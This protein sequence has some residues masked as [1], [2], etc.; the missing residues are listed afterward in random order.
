MVQRLLANLS[1]GGRINLGFGIVL[2]M[3]LV[4]AG[5]GILGANNARLLFRDFDATSD[6]T[7]A[8]LRAE[9]NIIDLSRHIL[10]Y[11]NQDSQPSLDAAR[12]L[13][14]TLPEVLAEAD[15]NADAD[16]QRMLGE[17]RNLVQDFGAAVEDVWRPRPATSPFSA[18]TWCRPAR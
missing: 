11:L 18:R 8:I 7:R 12:D 13:V 9:R 15:A 2:A 6:A 5:A 14:K 10:L 16:E 17:M 3:L 4:V 1:I